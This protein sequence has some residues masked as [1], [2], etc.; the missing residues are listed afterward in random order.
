MAERARESQLKSVKG[1]L[2]CY[3]TFL[4]FFLSK[5]CKKVNT[6][7]T[8]MSTGAAN[9][10][11]PSVG[12]SVGR[13]LCRWKIHARKRSDDDGGYDGDDDEVHPPIPG[14]QRLF[15]LATYEKQLLYRIHFILSYFVYSSCMHT[16]YI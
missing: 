16:S 12:G 11:G 6:D 2:I 3:F 1:D 10:S 7:K 14:V 15:C 4:Q 5:N 9:L 13:C 8:G